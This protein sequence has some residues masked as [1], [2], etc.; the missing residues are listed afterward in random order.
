[1]AEAT[2]LHPEYNLGG[3]HSLVYRLPLSDWRETTSIP[4]AVSGYHPERPRRT[5]R[6]R[7]HCSAST[8]RPSKSGNARHPTTHTAILPGDPRCQLSPLPMVMPCP[9]ADRVPSDRT[10]DQ[11]VPVS[12]ASAPSIRALASNEVSIFGPPP[13]FVNT[14]RDVTFLVTSPIFSHCTFSFR[15]VSSIQLKHVR[16]LAPHP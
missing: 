14:R 5:Q 7:Q 1:M 2:I 6:F 4:R 11:Y 13:R 12:V 16:P 10:T 3:Q 15:F 8:T 9:F